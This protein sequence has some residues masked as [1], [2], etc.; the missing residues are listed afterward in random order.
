MEDRVDVR[1]ATH[2]RLR[3]GRVEKIVS[4]WGIKSDGSFEKGGFGVVTESGERVSM[5]DAHS[6]LR[7]DGNEGKKE[8]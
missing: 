7:E 1:E 5:Y 2:V 3:G 8:K 4:K 6:Y